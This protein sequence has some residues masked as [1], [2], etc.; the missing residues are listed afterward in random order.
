MNLYKS[1]ERKRKREWE[2]TLM[3]NHIVCRWFIAT[4][5]T[6]PANKKRFQEWR[7]RQSNNMMCHCRHSHK[8]TEDDDGKEEYR[9]EEKTKE[10]NKKGEC[11]DWGN[12]GGEIQT[13]L[14][15][16]EKIKKKKK[17]KTKNTEK[18]NV[19]TYFNAGYAIR[20][21]QKK[22]QPNR[23]VNKRRITMNKHFQA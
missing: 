16:I 10:K 1:K 7:P 5:V 9:E 11:I 12:L 4:N 3:R 18:T 22:K 8:Q 23:E 15:A 21:H 6:N 2:D 13:T 14:D 20:T 19:K 17:K